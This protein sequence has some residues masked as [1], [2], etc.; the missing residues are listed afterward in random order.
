MTKIKLIIL[1]ILVFFMF[2]CIG[3]GNNEKE[4]IEQKNETNNEWLTYFSPINSSLENLYKI[5][6]YTWEYNETFDN[7]TREFKVSSNG[8]G[9]YVM[10][11]TPLETKEFFYNKSEIIVCE[12][13]DENRVC[14]KTG[15]DSTLL[16]LAAYYRQKLIENPKISEAYYETI[17]KN[18]ALN[19]IDFKQNSSCVMIVYSPRF[20]DLSLTDLRKI[21]VDPNDPSFNLY[22]N[23]TYSVCFDKQQGYVK[24]YSFEYT[25]QKNKTHDFERK[26]ISFEA[27]SSIPRKPIEQEMITNK[28]M[29]YVLYKSADLLREYY[30]CFKKT[31]DEKDRCFKTV[32]YENDNYRI[33]SEIENQTK[34]MSCEMILAT[35]LKDPNICKNII[36]K[37]E[38][39][40]E[41]ANMLQNQ[42]LCENIQNT[43]MK[44]QCNGLF[45]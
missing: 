7:I 6:E 36:Q 39:Y 4:P 16:S 10:V 14:A 33:C 32:A 24:I 5:K 37:N 19:L 27:K 28:S 3:N 20:G 26:T 12:K 25:D 45:E 18:N 29:H 31:G 9:S 21:N 1:T 38:C 43:T 22:S 30:N 34:K 40:L 23:F 35:K 2:G 8:N 15:N 17:L 44:E 42:T 41:L 13:Q 11:K